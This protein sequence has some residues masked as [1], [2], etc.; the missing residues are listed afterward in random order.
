[1]KTVTILGWNAGFQKVKFTELLRSDFGYS[2]SGA[3]AA[4][5]GIL[6]N[7]RLELSIPEGQY[8]H[9]QKRLVE[10]G[11]KVEIEKRLADHKEASN[12]LEFSRS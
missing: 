7:R 10:L 12:E 2:L 6:D 11:A 3:K 5:D 4:T 8:G 1:M 9:L